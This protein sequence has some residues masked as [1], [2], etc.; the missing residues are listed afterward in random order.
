MDDLNGTCPHCGCY[1]GVAIRAHAG[2]CELRPEAQAALAGPPLHDHDLAMKR[3][4]MCPVCLA[5]R[6]S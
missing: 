2:L 5:D 1:I 4:C 3:E 6:A